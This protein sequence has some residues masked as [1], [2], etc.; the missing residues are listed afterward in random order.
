[1]NAQRMLEFYERA[2]YPV[3]KTSNAYW[4]VPGRR[5]YKNFPCGAAITPS[6]EELSDL[7]HHRGILGA[8][9]FNRDGIGVPSGLWMMRDS[10]YDLHSVQRQFRQHL[11][12]ALEREQ[13][14]EISFADLAAQATAANLETLGRQHHADAH[15]AD[16]AM[17]RRLC[18]AGAHVPGAGV[19]ASFSAHRLMAYLIYFVVDGTCYGLI[20]KSIDEAR[21][22]GSNHALY[23]TYTR[24]MIRRAEITA[25][26]LGL[27]SIPPI[28]GVDRM[29]RHAGHSLEPFHVAVSLRPF[30]RAL[31]GG[32]VGAIA[33]RA[34]ERILG[35]TDEIQRTRALHSILAATESA[36]RGATLDKRFV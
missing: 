8:E 27:Q 10:T 15:I 6:R 7:S 4:Y 22:T 16:P 12:P 18:N 32:R 26:T 1:M 30:A 25:V 23:F 2:G 28:E 13:V 34:A 14:R 3:A 35:S 33:L 20:S 29:K 9:F 11:V 21:H 17:W 19:F 36:S 24:T 5:F 31:I